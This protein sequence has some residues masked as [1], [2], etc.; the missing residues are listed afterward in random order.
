M[1]K[2]EQYRYSRFLD[3]SFDPKNPIVVIAGKDQY[4]VKLI[5]SIRQF[6][7]PVRL[8]AFEGET[9]PKLFN[10]FPENDRV[11]IKV[12]Q[13][14]KLLKAVKDFQAAYAIMAGQI[15][16]KRLFKGLSLDFK[17]I[18]ILMSLKEKNAETIFGAIAKEI[19]ALGV[20]Q[21]DA[22]AFLDNEIGEHGIMTGGKL[23]I[24]ES[25][26][27]HGIQV[28]RELA[29]L[30]IG[31]GAV[32]RNGTVLAAEAFEGTDKMLDRAGEFAA[33]N[34][35]FVKTSK[36]KQDFRFDVPVF[37]LKTIQKMIDN[38]IDIVALEAD[39]VIILDKEN[40]LEL[41][42]KNKIQIIGF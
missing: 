31:Q 8:I 25:Y 20:K 34:T 19:E 21:L 33:N 2:N 12:G 22:R 13:L 26:L 1:A 27:N 37:G 32:V 16:P 11:L 4:P 7:L 30:N 35:L 29:R 36:L 28:T 42:K 40:V 3:D 24:Q 15:T 14:G 5:Q 9:C 38:K 17:A 10:S 18:R 6:N 39:K 41:A 23:R